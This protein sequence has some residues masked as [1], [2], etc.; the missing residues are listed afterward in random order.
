MAA[1]GSPDEQDEPVEDEKPQAPAPTKVTAS[2][3]VTV[4]P[5]SRVGADAE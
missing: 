4:P 3:K 1:A 2:A 5:S